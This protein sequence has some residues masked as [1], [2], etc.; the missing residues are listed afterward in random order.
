MAGSMTKQFDFI[1]NS[2][3]HAVSKKYDLKLPRSTAFNY[4]V[5]ES[6]IIHSEILMRDALRP[7][8]VLLGLFTLLTGLAYPLAV[9]GLAQALFPYQ[10]NG[11]LITHEG[12][13]IGSALIGQNFATPAYFHGRPSATTDSDPADATKTVASPYNAAAS[14]AS[15]LA[16]SAQALIDRV[17]ADAALLHAENPEAAVPVELVTTSASGLD[18]HISMAA[19]LFQVPRVAQARGLDPQVLRDLIIVSTQ[20]RLLGVLGEPVINVLALNRALDN[21]APHR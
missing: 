4:F 13:I 20:P 17:R 6:I 14:G 15:N 5:A 1:I 8:L 19:A 18:P 9:T 3:T 11:S 12:T 16:P 21:V 10:A 2:D 7:A